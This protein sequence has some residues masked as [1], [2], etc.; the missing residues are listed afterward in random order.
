MEKVSVVGRFDGT[1]TTSADGRYAYDGGPHD[2]NE[3]YSADNFGDNTRESLRRRFEKL[4]VVRSIHPNR[5]CRNISKM[6]ELDKKLK[7]LQ[8]QTAKD[9]N[10]LEKNLHLWLSQKVA[11]GGSGLTKL[12][13]GGLGAIHFAAALGY[14]WAIEAI[15]VAAEMKIDLRDNKGWTA[16]HGA[17]EPHL[18]IQPHSIFSFTRLILLIVS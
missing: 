16:L 2:W 5:F 11:E 18:K 14:D 3:S 17:G 12:D 9:E 6:N 1:W 13:K 15:I 7:S 8:K 10:S 4:L